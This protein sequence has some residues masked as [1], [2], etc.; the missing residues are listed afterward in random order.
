MDTLNASTATANTRGTAVAP[1]PPAPHARAA[2]VAAVQTVALPRAAEGESYSVDFEVSVKT[3]R[4]TFYQISG[5]ST[6]LNP[7]TGQLWNR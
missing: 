2:G 6:Y 3:N 5:T 7:Q 1:P 4:G